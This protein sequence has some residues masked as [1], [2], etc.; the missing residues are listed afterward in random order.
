M[1]EVE[2][3]QDTAR[4]ITER[5]IE[6]F[7]VWL[8]REMKSK[9]VTIQQ[10]ADRTGITYTGIWNIVK[11]NTASPRQ[12]TREKIALAL[13]AVVP[14]QIEKEATEQSTPI[15]GYE[16]V[17]FTP[18]DLLT[19]P[20]ESGIYVFYDITDR[21]VYVGKSNK[22][23]QGR[24]KDHQTRFWFK[25]PLVVRGAFLAVSDPEMCDKIE[26]I[27]IKF[28][29]KHALMNQKGAVRDFQE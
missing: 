2:R 19:V 13:G 25:Y 7:S 22:S 9:G 20:S 24:V 29:G 18:S 6:A 4:P 1:E 5:E 3:E 11:G 26:I 23:V 28:L 12:D 16:W 14:E 10:M 17:D 8:D 27:L 21:P 15:P